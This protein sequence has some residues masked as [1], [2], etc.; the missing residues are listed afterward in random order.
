MLGKYSRVF[1]CFQILGDEIFHEVHVNPFLVDL[2]E[3][4]ISNLAD[5]MTRR[6]EHAQN[7]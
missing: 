1:F 3:I 5:F 4:I 2:T 7:P 6:R